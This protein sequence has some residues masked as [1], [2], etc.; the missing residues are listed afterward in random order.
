MTTLY[1]LQNQHGYYLKKN[2]SEK[3]EW[4]DG[5]ELSALFRTSHKDEAVNMMFE[6]NAQDFSLRITI[7]EYEA[8]AKKHP[9]IPADDLP[10]PLPKETIAPEGKD[11]AHTDSPQSLESTLNTTS[12]N[13]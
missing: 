10:P 3:K 13:M 11:E 1:L 5:R 4:D 6:T 9:I 2:H 8:N 12:A 7:R